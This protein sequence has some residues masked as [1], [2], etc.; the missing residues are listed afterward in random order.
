MYYRGGDLLD[1]ENYY[2]GLRHYNFFDGFLY[3]V[4]SLGA[5]EPVYYI[6]TFLSSKMY[7]PHYFLILILNYYLIVGFLRNFNQERHFSL[8]IA[9]CMLVGFHFAML[10]TELERLKIGFIFVFY[11]ISS[12][13]LRKRYLLFSLGVLSHFS[14]AIL[15]IVFI[16]H[17]TLRPRGWK[18][19]FDFKKVL[20]VIIFIAV[21]ILGNHAA[22]QSKVQHYLRAPDYIAFIE[23]ACLAIFFGLVAQNN[24]SIVVTLGFVVSLLSPVFGGGR[25][26][27]LV[28]PLFFCWAADNQKALNQFLILPLALYYLFRGIMFAVN[29][30]YT[31]RGITV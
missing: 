28:L 12:T 1:Y 31:G 2:L 17:D 29:V 5:A 14:I 15:L 6:I 7:I 19:H 30:V 25:L 20:I 22:I 10:Y 13:S 11:A 26:L 3:Y 18:V 16:I 9:F 27:I 8:F 21:L 24:R 4:G 23:S